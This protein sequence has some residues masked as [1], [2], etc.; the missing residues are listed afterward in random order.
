[1]IAVKIV[2]EDELGKKIEVNRS[3]NGE[4]VGKNLDE[5]ESLISEIQ[6]ETMAASE[7]SL[8]ELNQSE[9]AKKKVFNATDTMQ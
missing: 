8:L 5:I 3:Y 2:I 7:L 1:M 4:L 6:A 9:A